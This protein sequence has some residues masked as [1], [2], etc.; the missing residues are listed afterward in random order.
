MSLRISVFNVILYIF[1]ACGNVYSND[2]EFDVLEDELRKSS[3]RKI[4][5]IFENKRQDWMVAFIGKGKFYNAAI[6]AEMDRLKVAEEQAHRKYFEYPPG[7]AL[8]A[9]YKKVSDDLFFTINCL[10]LEQRLVRENF[11]FSPTGLDSLN[12]I[13]NV[14]QF[15]YS[16]EPLVA[17]IR[18]SWLNGYRMQVR[19]Y[20]NEILNE[21]DELIKKSTEAGDLEASKQLKRYRELTHQR[22]SYAQVHRYWNWGKSEI[23]ELLPNGEARNSLWR[24][25]LGSWRPIDQDLFELQSPN[26]SV[27]RLSFDYSGSPKAVVTSNSGAKMKSTPVNGAICI[28]EIEKKG[29]KIITKGNKIVFSSGKK[30]EITYDS[31]VYYDREGNQTK[32]QLNESS[33]GENSVTFHGDDG[34]EQSIVFCGCGRKYVLHNSNKAECGVIGKPLLRSSMFGDWTLATHNGSKFLVTISKD[35]VVLTFKSGKTIDGF[36]VDIDHKGTLVLV[37]DE[38]W[39][40]FKKLF[41][42]EPHIF[43]CTYSI[44]DPCLNISQFRMDPVKEKE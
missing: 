13:T 20:H 25:S 41:S 42:K 23:L 39:Y 35:K 15:N 33:W 28:G 7:N 11:A 14:Q 5:E 21:I 29:E 18:R 30:F 27:F 8:R 31:V 6:S 2:R 43:G 12:R 16:P 24:K 44:K 34:S 3:N 22:L 19:D 37:F 32:Y 26:G 4:R 17:K 38:G 40:E 9:K 36:L 1:L 10:E